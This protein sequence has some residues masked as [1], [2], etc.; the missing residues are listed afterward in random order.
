MQS[1]IPPNYGGMVNM[2]GGLTYEPMPALPAVGSGYPSQPPASNMGMGMHAN[3]GLDGTMPA[4]PY[5]VGPPQMHQHKVTTRLHHRPYTTIFGAAATSKIDVL[6]QSTAGVTEYA[7]NGISIKIEDLPEKDRECSICYNKYGTEFPEGIREAPRRLPKCRHVFGDYCLKI[8]L[9]QS[10]SCPYCRDKLPLRF[11][12]E[13]ESRRAQAYMTYMRAR[14]RVP[15]PP[16]PPGPPLPGPP[17]PPGTSQERHSGLMIPA[18]HDE[19]EVGEGHVVAILEQQLHRSAETDLSAFDSENTPSD[20]SSAPASPV[21]ASLRDVSRFTQWS[22]SRA[23]Q[24]LVNRRQRR[25]RSNLP[26][27]Q[28]LQSDGSTQPSTT[29]PGADAREHESSQSLGD[30]GHGS[31]E[32]SMAPATTAQNRNRP[33]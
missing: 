13:F 25:S 19:E 32:I 24:Q 1:P 30:A 21:R 4:L 27:V 29:M 23:A 31:A 12:H 22:S 10:I 28:P 17:G 3:T 26:P 18:M 14:A 2:S 11:D 9:K 20:S 5:Y 33:W 6:Q 8:W 15:V 7:P 16:E